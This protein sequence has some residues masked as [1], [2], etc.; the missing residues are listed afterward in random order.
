MDLY[1]RGLISLEDTLGNAT[2]PDDLLLKIKGISQVSGD[3][4]SSGHKIDRFGI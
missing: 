1:N 2:N 4:T 3:V